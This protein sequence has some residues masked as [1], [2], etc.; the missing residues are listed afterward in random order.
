M[1]YEMQLFVDRCTCSLGTDNLVGAVAV[2]Y[3]SPVCETLRDFVYSTCLSYCPTTV[4]VVSKTSWRTL[5]L[6]RAAFE[7]KNHELGELNKKV[8]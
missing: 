1:T 6:R 4:Y 2:A 3:Q 8:W 7:N 5:F